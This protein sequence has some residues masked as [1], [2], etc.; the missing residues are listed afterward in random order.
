MTRTTIVLTDAQAEAIRIY[1]RRT[2]LK[3]SEVLRRIVDDWLE[4]QRQQLLLL[5]KEE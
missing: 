2:E 3:F 1:A 5:K 4:R